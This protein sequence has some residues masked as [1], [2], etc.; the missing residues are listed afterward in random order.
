MQSPICDGVLLNPITH[1][2]TP[3]GANQMHPNPH[4]SQEAPSWRALGTSR[5]WS[6][7]TQSGAAGSTKSTK[8]ICRTTGGV[9]LRPAERW[10]ERSTEIDLAKWH[11]DHRMYWFN[12]MVYRSIFS[13]VLNQTH[14]VI[15]LYPA[16]WLSL[17]NPF[18]LFAWSPGLMVR[19]P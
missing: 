8:H 5:Q 7:G 1:T 18:L 19:N 10:P 9:Q 17:K 4:I 15:I 16:P 3:F 6:S 11:F 13:T 2:T 12:W 14:I